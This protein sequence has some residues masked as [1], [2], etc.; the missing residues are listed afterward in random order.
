[1]GFLVLVLSACFPQHR[2]Q[3]VPAERDFATFAEGLT[4]ESEYGEPQIIRRALTPEELRKFQ[5]KFRISSL[6]VHPRRL[7]IK[8]GEL[9]SLQKLI[10]AAQGENGKPMGGVPFSLQMEKTEPMVVEPQREDARLIKGIR[11]GQVD[12]RIVSL[13]P[14]LDGTFPTARIRVYVR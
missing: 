5:N 11:P 6:A 3:I 9:F 4:A 7:E 2:Q 1:M 10:I 12:L 8:E 13:A 14:R